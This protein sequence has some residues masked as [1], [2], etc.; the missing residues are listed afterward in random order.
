MELTI[1]STTLLPCYIVSKYTLALKFMKRFAGKI[2]PTLYSAG[3]RIM[4]K[5]FW[6]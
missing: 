1:H 4:Y 2:R 5:I 6:P 3:I